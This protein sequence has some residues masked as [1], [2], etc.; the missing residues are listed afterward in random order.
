MTTISRV[1]SLLTHHQNLASGH[2]KRAVCVER[3][4][5]QNKH[6]SKAKSSTSAFRLVL[7]SSHRNR[8]YHRW[9]REEMKSCLCGHIIISCQLPILP[10]ARLLFAKLMMA[11]FIL[12]L[13]LPAIVDCNTNCQCTVM[14]MI[15]IILYLLKNTS[16]LKKDPPTR[17][18]ISIL[19]FVHTHLFW[20]GA[21]S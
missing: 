10:E 14:L 7:E 3:N 11:L 2:N 16:L 8:E 6:S 9:C 5:V 12:S 4:I 15:S 13:W 17:P 18:S 1:L 19:T 20:I 21:L